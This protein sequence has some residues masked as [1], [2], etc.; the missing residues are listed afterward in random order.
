MGLSAL[1]GAVGGLVGG[2]F[3]VAVS[4]VTAWREHAGW[5]LFLLPVAGL[6]SVWIT[7]VA[8]SGG[9]TTADV[10]V[11]AGE[12][13]KP[14][15]LNLSVSMFFGTVLTHLFGGS[16]GKE[17]A[18]LQIGGGLAAIVNNRLR[19]EER[20]RR[21][22]TLCGMAA[23][24]AAVFGT[25]L[26]ASVFVIEGARLRRDRLWEWLPCSVSAWIAVAVSQ[27]K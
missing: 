18:A 24:F 21:T 9:C 8:K 3:A 22:L 10:W 1:M 26:T 27:A 19:L 14:L 6:L 2:R 23:L 15:P 7:R 13:G 16:A 12:A 20:Y 5:L 17:G 4:A 11:S 25:P